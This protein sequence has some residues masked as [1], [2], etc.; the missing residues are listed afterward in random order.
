M[1][2]YSPTDLDMNDNHTRDVVFKIGDNAVK[3][4]TK[5]MPDTK[6]VYVASDA[7]EIINYL[8]DESPSWAQNNQTN[9]TRKNVTILMRPNHANISLHLEIHPTEY[10]KPSNYSDTF[11]DLWIMAH[12]KCLSQGLGGFGHFGSVLSGN[13][14]SC[15]VRHR[16]YFQNGTSLSSCPTPNELKITKLKDEIIGVKQK[17]KDSQNKLKEA[18]EEK[19][20]VEEAK[21]YTEEEKKGLM[22]ELE[23]QKIKVN[24]TEMKLKGVEEALM[25]CSGEAKAQ[26]EEEK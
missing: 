22:K 3:C 8:L 1:Q 15:R 4:A 2:R 7:H 13:H 26:T 14:Y 20:A 16:D 5:A 24:E 17:F 6:Y 18:R 12:S 9:T 10:T 21:A 19:I 11:L 25:K 23:L